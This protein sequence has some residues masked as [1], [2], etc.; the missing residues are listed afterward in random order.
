MPNLNQIYGL[1]QRFFELSFSDNRIKDYIEKTEARDVLIKAFES[2]RINE[3][4]NET[5]LFSFLNENLNPSRPDLIKYFDEEREEDVALLFVDITSF[6]KTISGWSNSKIKRFL[7]DYYRT[8]IPII[9]K[10][11]GEIEKLM[12][13][14]II[15]VFGKPF[16]N[17]PNPEYVYKAEKCAEEIIKT[18]FGTDKNI[19]AAIHKG[20]IN[21]YKVPGE[22]YG[23]YTIIGQPITDLYRLESVSKSNAVNFYTDS[24]YDK[25]GWDYCIYDSSL[26]TVREFDV[27]NLQG[28]DFQKVKYLR[29]DGFL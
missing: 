5:R 17:L 3:S 16:L 6:S 28:V 8:I 29:F 12:G 15:I 20:K 11:G 25:L 27:E 9:Y 21:Y 7:D 10:N 23:E 1:K 14:G 2:G 13:D 18:F 26:L 4:V 24:L 19:K 22:H